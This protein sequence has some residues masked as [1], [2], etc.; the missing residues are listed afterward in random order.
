MYLPSTQ[1][2]QY[3]NNI[4]PGGQVY[5]KE[6]KCVFEQTY[7]IRVY[8][9]KWKKQNASISERQWKRNKNQ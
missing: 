6:L 7:K 8:K 5:F 3:V 1:N 9:L 2:T 4:T